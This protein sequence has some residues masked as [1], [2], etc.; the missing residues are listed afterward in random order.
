MGDY[1]KY[2]LVI[3]VTIVT[4]SAVG[5]AKAVKDADLSNLSRVSIE[6]NDDVS[7]GCWTNTKTAEVYV[8][9]ELLSAGVDRDHDKQQAYVQISAFG[10]K[11][12]AGT[13]V[14]RYE[15]YI[16]A[17][18]KLLDDSCGDNNIIPGRLFSRSGLVM[19]GPSY[20]TNS[21]NKF[22]KEAASELALKIMKDTR[23]AKKS[24]K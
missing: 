4:M 9:K 8:E 2:L 13:C 17:F 5:S 1:M 16:I 10:M 24:S 20:T 22:F 14:V 21:T 12:K 19:G 6:V 11:N 23:A 15:L 18:A 7:N 3:L